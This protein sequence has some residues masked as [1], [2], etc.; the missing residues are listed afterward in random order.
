MI[1][2]QLYVPPLVDRVAVAVVVVVVVAEA[3][4]AT[5]SPCC[6]M[7][8][9]TVVVV[10]FA[11]LGSARLDEKRASWFDVS[12]STTCCFTLTTFQFTPAKR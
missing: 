7:V 3:S 1:I 8:V 9:V 12:H 5:P 2:V 4:Q 11:R 6:A 10:D